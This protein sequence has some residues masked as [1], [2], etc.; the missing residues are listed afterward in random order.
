MQQLRFFGKRLMNVQQETIEISRKKAQAVIKVD[1]ARAMGIGEKDLVKGAI[2]RERERESWIK[3]AEAPQLVGVVGSGSAENNLCQNNSCSIYRLRLTS[4]L[5]SFSRSAATVCS[6][7][8]LHSF[9]LIYPPILFISLY[10]SA[11]LGSALFENRARLF[12]FSLSL[13]LYL[14]LRLLHS[15]IQPRALLSMAFKSIS[16]IYSRTNF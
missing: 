12:C 5:Y 14:Y 8:P 4:L 16:S 15:L 1:V 2:Q 13:S 6:V 9:P 3:N 11:R 7:H 10:A